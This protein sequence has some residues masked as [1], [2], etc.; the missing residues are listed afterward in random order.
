MEIKFNKF[1]N[2]NNK[3]LDIFKNITNQNKIFDFLEKLNDEDLNTLYKLVFSQDGFYN[4]LKS[5]EMKKELYDYWENPYLYNPIIDKNKFI[6][7]A[8]TKNDLSI[9]KKDI[10]TILDDLFVKAKHIEY[11][12]DEDGYPD[13]VTFSVV[14]TDYVI[15]YK[16]LKNDFSD[17]VIAKRKFE[18]ELEFMEKY[19]DDNGYNL[20][21]KINKIEL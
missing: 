4:G 2:E 19:V 7:E 9:F 12:Y 21:F 5:K 13:E 10:E 6:N 16:K 14:R 8:K 15:T 20:V 17:G 11:S 1:I 18:P 3:I